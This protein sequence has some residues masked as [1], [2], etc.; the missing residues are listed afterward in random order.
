MTTVN[1]GWTLPTVGASVNAW[2]TLV[3]TI[4]T[5]IDA[6][7]FARTGGAIS[8]NVSVAGTGAFSDLLVG[9]SAA[10]QGRIYVRKDSSTA[11][12]IQV[13]NESATGKMLSFRTNG[14]TQ[15]GSVSFTAATVTYNTTSDYRLKNNI[16]PADAKRF[17]E[18]EFFD[19][20]WTDGRHDCGVIADQL[21]KVYPGLV[22]G[23]KD[24]TEIRDVEIKP[25]IPAVSDRRLMDIPAGFTDEEIEQFKAAAENY[26]LVEVTPEIPAVTEKREFPVY[27]QVNYPGL[28]SRTGVRVQALQR[29]VDAQAEAIAALTARIEA[30]EARA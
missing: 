10:D 5:D 2:G 7:M 23:E 28:I 17:M 22:L 25:A 11:E 14:N 18:I 20:E 4:L 3:N 30:L 19:F 6:K 1:Y 27:Q 12:V 8:G 15:V 26:E 29:T 13:Q 16:R 24:A 21:A 9:V